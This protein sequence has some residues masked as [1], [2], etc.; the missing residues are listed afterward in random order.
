[1][2]TWHEASPSVQAEWY[3]K[4]PN[5]ARPH[6]DR[7]IDNVCCLYI[8]QMFILSIIHISSNVSPRGGGGGITGSRDFDGQWSPARGECKSPPSW[9]LEVEKAWEPE[10]KLASKRDNEVSCTIRHPH[11]PPT[12]S[13]LSECF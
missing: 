8:S 12:C 7:T 10:A 1:M 2:K 4:L 6:D 3:I 13:P 5:S 11:L 9:F